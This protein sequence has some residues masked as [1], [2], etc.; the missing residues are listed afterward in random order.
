MSGFTDK[1]AQADGVTITLN[2]GLCGQLATSNHTCVKRYMRAPRIV[3]ARC[4][5]EPQANNPHD[6]FLIQLER[7]GE[8]YTTTR[9]VLQRDYEEV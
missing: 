4:L 5:A 7:G 3:L 2:C 8:E 9:E 1:I 6:L